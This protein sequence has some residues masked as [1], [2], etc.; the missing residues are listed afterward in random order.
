MARLALS[1]HLRGGSEIETGK[2]PPRCLQAGSAAIF[3][4]EPRSS[5]W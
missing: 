3:G 5:E 4:D 1:E 2:P